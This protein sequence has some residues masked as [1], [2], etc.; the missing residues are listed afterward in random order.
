MGTNPQR[1]IINRDDWVQEVTAELSGGN[2]AAITLI[3]HKD[4]YEPNLEE[5]VRRISNGVH[6]HYTE[7]E[8][9]TDNNVATWLTPVQEEGTYVF[10]KSS[11]THM[12]TEI[13]MLEIRFTP[14]SIGELTAE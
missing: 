5:G 7:P 2:R 13:L 12:G 11:G 4:R 10:F 6:G 14:H 9:D 8:C 1:T 3:W